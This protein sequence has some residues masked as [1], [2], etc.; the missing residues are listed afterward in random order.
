MTLTMP[1]RAFLPFLA[2]SVVS[3]LVGEFSPVQAILKFKAAWS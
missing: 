3:L 1:L 2:A